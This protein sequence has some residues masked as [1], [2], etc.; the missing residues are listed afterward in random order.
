MKI[1]KYDYLLRIFIVIIVAIIGSY[2]TRENLSW[3]YSNKIE[4]SKY[5]P[6]GY[7]FGIVWTIIYIGYAYTWCKSLKLK[8]IN[9]DTIFMISILLNLLW[10]VMFFGFQHINLSIF[11]MIMLIFV[12]C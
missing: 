5:M 7:I 4:R 6:K 1:T 8:K 3:L 12:N 9:T 11:I 10:V 2:I